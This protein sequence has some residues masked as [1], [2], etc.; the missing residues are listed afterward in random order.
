[1][2]IAANITLQFKGL[3]EEIL[4][5]KVWTDTD[6]YACVVLI[7]ENL[8]RLDD[9]LTILVRTFYFYPFQ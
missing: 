8:E 1:M 3:P 6:V 9:C 2:D 7:R 4:E 5:K